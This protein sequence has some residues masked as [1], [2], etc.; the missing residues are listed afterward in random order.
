MGLDV[1]IKVRVDDEMRSTLER[2][3]AAEERSIGMI[4]RRAIRLYVA[5]VQE[6][7]REEAA[8]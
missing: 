5:A 6:A 2:V 4:I 8:A 3:A 7:E 1:N